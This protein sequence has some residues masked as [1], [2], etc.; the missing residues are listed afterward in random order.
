ML[1]KKMTKLP[2][3]DSFNGSLHVGASLHDI[4]N[5]VILKEA[6]DNA[7]PDLF[8]AL[9]YYAPAVAARLGTR[10]SNCIFFL[11]E[12]QNINGIIE[13]IYTVADVTGLEDD[14][15]GRLRASKVNIRPLNPVTAK[16]LENSLKKPLT[17]HS[18]KLGTFKNSNGIFNAT[19]V[20]FD[21]SHYTTIE[22]N[23]VKEIN[24]TLIA[25]N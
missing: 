11:L 19:I 3:A 23:K 10:H 16:L 7:G 25:V 22:D 4:K 18:G 8:F 14:G 21:G 6:E 17:A 9:D 1:F 24:G 13:Q 15:F 12:D 2:D 5:I 20:S